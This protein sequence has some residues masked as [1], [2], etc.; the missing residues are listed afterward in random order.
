[1]KIILHFIK[2]C[3][4]NEI[5]QSAN[6][7]T[8]KLLLAM[9]PFLIFLITLM[10]FLNID[11][12]VFLKNLNTTLPPDI[13]H[14]IDLFI[15]ET[16][17]K[18]QVSLLSIGLLVTIYSASSG[19]YTVIRCLKR[20]FHDDSRGFIKERLLSLNLLL[21]FTI[22]ILIC[23][24]PIFFN[25]PASIWSFCIL[26]VFTVYTYDVAS[27]KHLNFLKSLPGAILVVFL[28]V[29]STRLMNIYVV[30][31]SRYSPVYGGIGSVFILLIWLNMM[32]LL[33][34]FGA[35]LNKT[36]SE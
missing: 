34:L 27:V 17:S 18:K 9:F 14:F 1:M 28:M 26:C 29:V 31:F 36:L 10:G 23:C 22:S 13:Y 15:N 5:I 12:A 4:K 19:F 21:V 24:V 16:V 8:Y 25:L 7:L 30:R 32:S 33:L 20:I 35:Q 2:E 11:T 6:E 3:N